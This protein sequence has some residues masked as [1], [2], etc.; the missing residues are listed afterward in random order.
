MR[1]QGRLLGLDYG[2]VRIGVAISD[3]ERRIA[4]PVEVYHRRSQHEDA[5]YF[6][7]L[8][9]QKNIT[10]IV[11]GLPRRLGGEEGSAAEAARHF[12]QWLQEITG[13]RV[14]YW[15]E[16]LTTQ[17]AERLMQKAGWTPRTRREKADMIAAQVILQSYLDAGCPISP[18][19]APSE[20]S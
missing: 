14:A 11:V 19:T 1:P 18:Q 15:D 17:L 7:R 2:E 3:P 20:P 9:F 10:G 12:G 16:R 5:D 8:V 6:R 4:S 13:L